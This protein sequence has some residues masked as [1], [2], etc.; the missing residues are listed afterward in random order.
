MNYNDKKY[1]QLSKKITGNTLSE[2]VD[3]VN[4]LSASSEYPINITLTIG[5]FTDL[6]KWYLVNYWKQ[7]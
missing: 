5:D 3:N 1:I 4:L 7:I 2:L 6:K